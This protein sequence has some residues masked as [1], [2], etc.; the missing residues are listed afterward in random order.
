MTAR[1]NHHRIGPVAA[2]IAAGTV[3]GVTGA[4]ALA[5]AEQSAE[6]TPRQQALERAAIAEWATT[7]GLTGLSPAALTPNERPAG[8]DASRAAELQA[9]AEFARAEGLTGLSP[10]S[11]Q[12]V[13]D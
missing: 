12:P 7:N 11:L 5:A 8:F 1:S 9:I 3:F 6:L 4:F 10:A 2:I 13:G